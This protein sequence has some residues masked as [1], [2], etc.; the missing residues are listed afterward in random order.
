MSGLQGKT[1]VVVGGSRGLGRG[2]AEV[3]AQQGTRV[4]VIARNKADLNSL[5][6]DLDGKIEVRSAD[7]TDESVAT[8]IVQQYNPDILIING[9]S[10]P[11][12]GPIHEL[13]WEEFSVNWETDVKGTFVWTKA[14]MQKPLKPG[15]N[16]VIVSSGAAL[17]GSPVSGGYAGSKRMQW[18]MTNY[19]R[20]ESKLSELGIHFHTLLPLRIVADTGVGNRGIQSYAARYNITPEKFLERFGPDLTPTMFGEGVLEIIWSGHETAAFGINGEGLSTLES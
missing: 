16:V 1:A 4:L 13:S 2:V 9:G 17:N 6:A 8:E 7:M 20:E 19:L 11:P 18:L 12:G 14:A 5:K 15:S 10:L 3:L